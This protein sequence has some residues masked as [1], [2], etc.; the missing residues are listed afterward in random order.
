MAKV[1]PEDVREVQNEQLEQS[2][3][4]MRQAHIAI[5]TETY[6]ID[7]DALGTNLPKRYYL[8][9]GFIGTVT[10]GFQ[11]ASQT[12]I[13]S[14]TL[15]GPMSWQHQQLPRLDHAIQLPTPNQ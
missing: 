10:V 2:V 5:H 7:V 8:S 15:S 14:R 9:P 12:H 4:S 3:H 6:D 13:Y 1:K 11:S